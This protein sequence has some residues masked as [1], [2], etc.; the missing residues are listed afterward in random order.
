MQGLWQA[1]ER[2]GDGCLAQP[3]EQCGDAG[4]QRLAE[5]KDALKQQIHDTEKN[6]Q[7]K[8]R[9]QQHTVEFF[10]EI[11]RQAGRNLHSLFQHARHLGLDVFVLF[12]LAAQVFRHARSGVAQRAGD[13]LQGVR[14]AC[15]I[16][17]AD[18]E[19]RHF[20]QFRHFPAVDADA[21]F[22][23]FIAHVEQHHDIH[24]ECF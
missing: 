23:G 9:V 10:G 20:Q 13:G 15:A 21:V 5:E 3:G 24:V 12:Q 11:F 2:R 22:F 6:R 7:T 8:P 18:R 19:D 14:I 1:G 4:L 16:F 17:S